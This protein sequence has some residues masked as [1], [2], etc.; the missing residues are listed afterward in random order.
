VGINAGYEWVRARGP[1]W[2]AGALA[3]LAVFALAHLPQLRAEID[4][5]RRFQE[6]EATRR[7]IGE[8][9]R[10]H[11][12]PA[13]ATA[14]EAGGYQGYYSERRVI[15][16]AGLVS[17][18]VTD[19]RRHVP[20]AATSFFEILRRFSP[21]AIVLR[22]FEV[23]ENRHFHGGPLFATEEQRRLFEDHYELG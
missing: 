16:L 12:P 8:W 15:D 6:N 22:G 17:R 14:M 21:G 19:I 7:A 1:V 20:D 2:R 9:L 11:T 18:D 23:R 13:A 4:D 3:S 10:S 5:A